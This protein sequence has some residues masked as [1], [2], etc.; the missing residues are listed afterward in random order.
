MKVDGTSG[1]TRYTE[2]LVIIPDTCTKI[3]VNGANDGYKP[4]VTTYSGVNQNIINIGAVK[5]YGDDISAA[6]INANPTYT[7]LR[8]WRTNIIYN[9]GADVYPLVTDLP[10]DFTTYGSIVKFNGYRRS[11]YQSS[12]KGYSSYFLTGGDS[13]WFGFDTGSGI[14]WHSLSTGTNR[15][16]LFIGDSYAQGYSHDGVN[17]GWVQYTIDYLNLPA[18][19]YTK[20]LN[21]GASFSN[22]NNSF[23]TLLNN[24]A[25]KDYTDIVVAGGFNDFPYTQTEIE[26]AISAF[27][28]R[29]KALY[30]TAKIHIGCIG[31]IKQ[32]STADA[33]SNWADVRTAIETKVIPAYENSARYG[34]GYM[35]NT[36]FLLSDNGLTPSDGYHPSAE[37]NQTIATGIANAVLTGS[38]PLP[39][40]R[41]Y[42]Q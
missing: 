24:A 22:T 19:R 5:P 41:S 6:F 33:Y 9:L 10:T 30:P 13:A 32:G 17:D 21:G 8:N 28:S 31:W 29:A 15:T 11:D 18:E 40:R 38:A 36:E 26:N 1:D 39:Y 42:R 12:W 2:R 3:I 14:A 7:S 16:Y 35:N 27:I 4:I 34:G 20:S 25:V 37:G 23:I